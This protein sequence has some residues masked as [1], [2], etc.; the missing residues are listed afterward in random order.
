MTSK[1]R[2]EA[3][4]KRRVAKRLAKKLKTCEHYDNYDDVFTYTNLFNAYKCCRK[5]VGWKSST[6]KYKANATLNVFKAFDKLKQ[7][8]FKTSGFYEFDINERGKTRH[9]KSVT[10]GER[11]VQR[12]LCD[13]SL[14]PM[15]SRRFI[16]DNAASLKNKG[17][18]FSIRR[19][20]EHLIRHYR[21][22]GTDGYILLYDFSKFFDNISHTEILN[23]LS[24]EYTDKRL[25]ELIK[26]F[27]DA[28]GDKGLGL[29]SQVSQILALTSANKLDHYIKE[30][31]HI[32]GYGRYMDD[33]YLI[34]E[35]KEYLQHC[36]RKIREKCK[37]LGIILNE[38]KTRI[39]KITHG[40]TFLKVRFFM[41]DTGKI[42][43]KVCKA[44]VTRMRRKLKK[45]KKKVE[46]GIMT[47]QDVYTS[48][49]SWRSHNKRLNSYHTIKNMDKL[50]NDLFVFNGKGGCYVL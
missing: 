8:K 24:K 2:H 18:D 9:I 40:F 27:I 31:L 22:H 4:Y 16:Y 50:Y 3:R 1:E 43:K 11:V 29:G 41:T 15:M 20:Q 42:V 37:E 23:V 5:N 21:K 17:Y 28:F 46:D 49:Q 14:V 32:K 38:K 47:L 10:M 19:I 33:G 48:Y 7:G 39:V 25:Y 6:Q 44:N 34:H 12:C 45:F 13:N 35:S 26:H 30:V 36:L